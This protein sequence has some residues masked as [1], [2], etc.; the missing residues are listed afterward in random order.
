[1][2]LFGVS[3]KVVLVLLLTACCGFF[4]FSHAPRVWP[5]VKFDFFE[6]KASLQRAGQ[7]QLARS[8]FSLDDSWLFSSTVVRNEAAMDYAVRTFGKSGVDSL[9]GRGAPFIWHR[10][11]FKKPGVAM[12]YGVQWSP[13]CGAMGWFRRT[14]KDEAGDSLSLDSALVLARTG[15]ARSLPQM[16]A[17]TGW[18]LAEQGSRRQEKRMDHWFLFEREVSAGFRQ[19][20]RA[21]IAG[22]RLIQAEAS[23][24]LPASAERVERQTSSGRVVLL[25]AAIAM[26]VLFGVLALKRSVL[27]LVNGS[28]RPALATKAVAIVGFCLLG[29]YALDGGRLFAEWDPL[30]PRWI[31]VGQTVMTRL[32]YDLPMLLMLFILVMAGD[33]VERSRG[34]SRGQ[35]LWSFLNGRW[36][37]PGVATGL[38][39][40]YPL[41][42]VAGSVLVGINL[43]F[44][45][46]G[47]AMQ[48]QPQGFF[49]YALNS[50]APG[51]ST[52]VFFLNIALLEEL[53]YRLFAQSY[54]SA[55]IPGWKGRWVAVLLPSLVFGA[56]HAP[57]YF[58]PPL[59]PW[60]GRVAVMVV[61]GVL[62]SLAAWRWG[63]LTVVAAHW[64]SD[65]F[66]FNWPRIAAGGSEA[67]RAGLVVAL[68]GLCGL[69][70]LLY[71]R[72]FARISGKAGDPAA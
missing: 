34:W 53:G 41:A 38:L 66:I 13:E 46:F 29:T 21:T 17:Q 26:M 10:L 33:H 51:V 2:Q 31:S 23:L 50:S 19:Q 43:I 60:W 12:I 27:A 48:V 16:W 49:S 22:S 59:D 52:L 1:M 55:V 15:L 14:E 39:T 9:Q 18:V 68:P 58:L 61:V 3:P 36:Q 20:L 8:D 4:F 6:D 70:V 37:D 35:S 65:L 57:M 54:L 44:L 30:W 67:L 40:G 64:A 32:V 7:E 56:I 72:F 11:L 5:L 62:W 28:A 69:A 71:N 24:A 25:Y 42:F 63:M 45:A 47:G